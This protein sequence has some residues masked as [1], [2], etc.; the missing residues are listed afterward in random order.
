MTS[1]KIMALG[2]I[3]AGLTACSTISKI[4]GQTDD[5]V[6]PG[7]REEAIP[8][9]AQ[10][11]ESSDVATAPPAAGQQTAAPECPADDPNCKPQSDGTF[12]DPQ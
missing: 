4:T 1:R 6:L 3:V 7:Q 11:P 2:L 9:K 8:G 12:S 5:T 10:F